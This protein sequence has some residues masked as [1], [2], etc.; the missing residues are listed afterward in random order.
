MDG[1]PSDGGEIPISSK[2]F[3]SDVIAQYLQVSR[4]LNSFESRLQKYQSD[5]RLQLLLTLALVMDQSFDKFS[6]CR[7][8]DILLGMDDHELH[9]VDQ[10]ALDFRHNRGVLRV[11]RTEMLDIT[12]R[13]VDGGKYASAALHCM[14]FLS[15]PP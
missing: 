7:C 5:G 11:S 12:F 15:N 4:C 9:L 10:N 1:Y 6:I 13:Y 2:L 14:A 3:I 8:L